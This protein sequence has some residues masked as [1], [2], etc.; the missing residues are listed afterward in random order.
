MSAAATRIR[1]AGPR[2]PKSARD[3]LSSVHK[4]RV[5]NGDQVIGQFSNIRLATRTAG[6]YRGS[7]V[8]DVSVKP[9][10]VVYQDGRL[11]EKPDTQGD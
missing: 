11:L 7:L 8:L 1:L 6:D 3:L 4:Y 2:L 5:M 9:P 10:H